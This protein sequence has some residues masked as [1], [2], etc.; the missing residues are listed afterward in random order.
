VVDVALDLVGVGPELDV[1]TDTRY[2]A[3]IFDF[4]GTLADSY[5]A[6]T[7]SVNHLRSVRGLPP[8][9]ETAVRELVGYGL[10]TLLAQVVPGGDLEADTAIYRA[11]YQKVMYAQTRLLPGVAATLAELQRRG[12]RLAVCSNKNVVFTRKLC[13]ALEIDRF[14]D[15]VLGPEDVAAPKPDPAMIQEALRR[16]QTTPDKCLYVGDMTVDVETARAAG[17]AVWVVPTGSHDAAT[18]AA[19]RPDRILQSMLE[20]PQALID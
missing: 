14:L 7:A 1:S 20:L 16:L 15:V 17:V 19:A 13:E 12:I 4:D 2:H 18:L 6:I 10:Q 3:I 9:P 5:A 8:M 11:H